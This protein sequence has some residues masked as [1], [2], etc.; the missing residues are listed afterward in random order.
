M[1]LQFFQ[2]S[3][4]VTKAGLHW[5]RFL[6]MLFAVV[7]SKYPTVCLSVTVHFICTPSR[8]K[9]ENKTDSHP[10][11]MTSNCYPHS[12]NSESINT[13]RNSQKLTIIKLTHWLNTGYWFS[14]FI[15]EQRFQAVP[16]A[17]Y[18]SG[19][20]LFCWEALW[21]GDG[22]NLSSWSFWWSFIWIQ[23][24]KKSRE[25]ERGGNDVLITWTRYKAQTLGL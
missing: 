21:V 24:P 6:R 9:I 18:L 10:H 2:Y 20:L 7:L 1:C 25:R 19:G 17:L 13:L 5:W 3:I 8:Q 23:R 12:M 14:F 11:L 4:N 15:H 22:M 16:F